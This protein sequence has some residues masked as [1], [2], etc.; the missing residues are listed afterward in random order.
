VRPVVAEAVFQEWVPH[1]EPASA[2][3]AEEFRVAA[4]APTDLVKAAEAGHKQQAQ[5]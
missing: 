2:P 1:L 5:L 3:Q 4:Q